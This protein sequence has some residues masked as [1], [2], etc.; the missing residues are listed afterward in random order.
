MFFPFN[1][2]F[3]LNLDCE[4]VKGRLASRLGGAPVVDGVF[5]KVNGDKFRAFLYTRSFRDSWRDIFYG[6]IIPSPEGCEIVGYFAWHRFV[7]VFS[8][9]WVAVPLYATFFLLFHGN[10]I[11]SASPFMLLFLFFL[12]ANPLWPFRRTARQ[13]VVDFIQDIFSD[14]II[15]K[16]INV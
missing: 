5:G 11:E 2:R 12:M 4:D 9:I 15:H 3:A 1:A 10:L 14:V 8:I 16:E 6:K 13:R 7:L